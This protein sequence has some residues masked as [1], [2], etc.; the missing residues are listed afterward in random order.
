MQ[1][2]ILKVGSKLIILP[3]KSRFG[4]AKRT[5]FDL[6]EY[7]GQYIRVWLDENLTFSMDKRK[8]HHWQVAELQV[9]HQKYSSTPTGVVDDAGMPEFVSEKIPIGLPIIKM[10]DTE[11]LEDD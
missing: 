5:E 6:S 3:F 10:F 9:P 4:L 11:I 8:N 2:E 7:A 1:P